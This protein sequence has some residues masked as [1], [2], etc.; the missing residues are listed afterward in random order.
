M[1]GQTLKHRLTGKQ[2]PVEQVLEIGAEIA[3]ALDAAHSKGII[4]RDVKPANIFVTNRGQAKILDFGLAKVDR[5][6][7]KVVGIGTSELPTV[8]EQDLNSPGTTL[9]T[10]AY[11]SP[12]QAR[13]EELDVRTDLFSFGVGLYEMA[14]GKL[15]FQGNTSATIFGA[16][17]HKAPTPPTRLNP[18]LPVKLEDVINKAIDRDVRY[19]H[20]SEIRADLKRLKRDTDSGH[21]VV[22][23]PIAEA[24]PQLW[25]RGG[26]AL[27]IAAVIV[28]V[29]LAAA[30]LSYYRSR[31]SGGETIN[32]LPVLP[33]VN[34]SGDPNT[35][36]LSDGITESLIN[37][38]SQLP[39][40]EVKS[41]DSAFHHKGKDSDAETV[42]RELGVRAI[43]KGRVTQVGDNL[44][45]SA[46]LIDARNNDH[47]WG[48]L[49]S[50]KASDIFALQGEIAKEMTTAL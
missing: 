16:I 41:R 17:L 9:G 21:S 40:L 31:T 6:E 2:W 3:D 22:G 42:G 33:F 19:Q 4:H 12:E 27:S 13:G 49:Y 38:L 30:G 47:I 24:R 48:E 32:S 14:T 36:Y 1:E 50:R 7:Q 45:I 46:E 11:M 23:A 18:E 26:I 15:P 44:D 25:W 8:S 10:V 34:G 35:E 28:I 43:F 29:L 39:K 5:K 37:S 20:A